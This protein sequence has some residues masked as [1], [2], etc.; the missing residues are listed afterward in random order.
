MLLSTAKWAKWDHTKVECDDMHQRI[1][2]QQYMAN[3]YWYVHV[4]SACWAFAGSHETQSEIWHTFQRTN[5][6][7]CANHQ[8]L[9][10][11]NNLQFPLQFCWQFLH[12]TIDKPH[13]LC[14]AVDWQHKELGKLSAQSTWMSTRQYLCYSMLFIS[15][16]I[17]HQRS[18]QNYRLWI[19]YTNFFERALPILFKDVPLNFCDDMWFQHTK[20]TPFNIVMKYAFKYLLHN[21]MFVLNVT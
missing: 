16:N 8:L 5:C 20:G 19:Q 1:C 11:D 9:S 18:G 3:R 17:Y 12:G 13:F 2:S 10:W 21:W 7:S 15:N 14:H 6:I 4:T